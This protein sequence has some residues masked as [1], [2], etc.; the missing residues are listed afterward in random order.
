MM[1]RQ[2]HFKRLAV[3][4]MFITTVSTTQGQD[5]FQ[6]RKAGRIFLSWGW[7]R[8]AYGKSTI[9]FKGADYDFTLFH[10]TAHDRPTKFSYHNYLK[11]SRLTIPQTN[12]R[13]SYF[14]K[15]DL[16]IS[17]GDDHMKYVMD[18]DQVANMK[19]VITRPGAFQG[20]YDRPF[21][22]TRNF[23]LFEHTDG[24]N[25]LNI[26][27]EK[28]KDLIRSRDRKSTRLNSSHEWISRMPSSA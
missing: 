7:N 16:A 1:L 24:L 21:T 10:L 20:T 3:L 18:N 9:H 19:G 14:I 11:F 2:V 23:L 8:A 27:L 26:E 12:L 6:D 22:V 13:I 5:R 17:F 25:Y 28:Y 4:L 15:D